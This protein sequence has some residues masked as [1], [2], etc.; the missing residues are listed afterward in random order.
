MWAK[1]LDSVHHEKLE[2]WH[3]VEES[4]SRCNRFMVLSNEHIETPPKGA[5]RCRNCVRFG[6]GQAT[7]EPK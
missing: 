5:K 7:Q 4:G 3:L 6:H 1:A 2:Y